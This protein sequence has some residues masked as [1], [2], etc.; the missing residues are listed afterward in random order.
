MPVIRVL[1]DVG[2]AVVAHPLLPHRGGRNS[3]VSTRETVFFRLQLEGIDYA[4]PERAAALLHD[5]FY[6]LPSLRSSARCVTA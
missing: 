2:D 4:A 6:E 3:S 1:L 5:P